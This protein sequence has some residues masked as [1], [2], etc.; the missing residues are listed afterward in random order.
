MRNVKDIKKISHWIIK[1]TD[2]FHKIH[3]VR[4]QN[5]AMK[6]EREDNL[7]VALLCSS[8]IEIF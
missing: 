8:N 7:I 1:N 6:N 4:L 2:I 3:T 5:D